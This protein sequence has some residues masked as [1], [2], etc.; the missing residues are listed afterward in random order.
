[1]H[2]HEGRPTGGVLRPDERD[3]LRPDVVRV[4][5]RLEKAGR[6]KSERTQIGEV[7]GPRQQVRGR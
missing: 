7:P 1:M 3:Q 4:A 2:G 5:G 6:Q